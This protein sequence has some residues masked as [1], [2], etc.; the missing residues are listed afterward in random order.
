MIERQK[1]KQKLGSARLA[2]C[3]AIGLIFPAVAGILIA[4]R[5]FANPYLGDTYGT[6]G[7]VAMMIGGTEKPSGNSDGRRRRWK[8]S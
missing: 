2:A 4:P 6:Y 8:T 5:T 3:A 7:F 1:K